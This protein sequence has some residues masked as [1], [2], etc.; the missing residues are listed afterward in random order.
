MQE[1]LERT[2]RNRKNIHPCQVT[3]GGKIGAHFLKVSVYT[4]LVL[5]HGSSL[6]RLLFK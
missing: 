4:Y 6:E 1:A 3:G 2:K 5:V